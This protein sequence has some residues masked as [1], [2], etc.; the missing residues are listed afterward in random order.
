MSAKERTAIILMAQEGKSLG[1]VARTLHRSPPTISREWRRQETAADAAGPRGYDARRMA[2][3]RGA[4][5]S[6]RAGPVSGPLTRCCSAWSS[7]SSRGVVARPVAGTLKLMGP[8]SL[9]L[10]VCAETIPTCLYAPPRGALRQE[11]IACLPKARN[12]RLPRSR[13][14]DRRGPL[15]DLVGIHVRPPE[16]EDRALPG[17]WQ[18]DFIKRAD[19]RSAVGVLVESR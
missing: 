7:I 17:H 5:T 11:L 13:G 9:D 19:N 3:K 14:T 18:G 10:R 8:D 15:S 2:K 12:S 4:G 1:A 16:V 6:S